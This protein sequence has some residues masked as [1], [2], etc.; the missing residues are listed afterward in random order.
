LEEQTVPVHPGA[1]IIGGGIAGLTSAE[2]LA[3]QGFKCTLVEKNSSLGGHLAEMK[4]TLAGE[5][6][7][8]VI[9]EIIDRVKKNRNIEV[10]TSSKL[11]EVSGFIGNFSSVIKTAAGKKE[12]ERTIEHGVIILATG[13]R[14]YRPDLYMLGKTKKVITQKELEI[15]LAGKAR[16]RA[17]D[18]VVMIQCAGS[19]GEDLTYCSKVCCGNAVKN[20]LK[21]KEINPDSQVMVLYRDMRTYGYAEDAYKK[22]REKGVVF[23]PYEPGQR[24]VVAKKGNSIDVTWLDP[25]LG[26]DV[27]FNPEIIVLSVGI[28]PEETRELGKKLKLSI[29]ENQFYM[30]AHVK[31]RPVEMSVDGVYVC[32]LAHSPKPVDEIIAQAQAAAG[33]AAIPLYKGKVAVPPVV[34]VID[35][36]KCIGCSICAKLCPYNA[37]QMIKEG[38]KPK[39]ETIVASCKGCGICASRCPSFAISMGGFT[40][41]QIQAQIKA[42]S[43]EF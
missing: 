5:S 29:N 23:I 16:K 41:E 37:I 32:G 17:P 25:I 13:G 19:R 11:Q 30:E 33:K 6:T 22:A 8:P 42:L 36:E 7:G 35:K 18:S 38:K 26:E 21:I 39:A 20:A 43:P 28:V 10:L 34:A 9:R 12:T 2:S 24:P 1:L 4:W 40:G 27:T 15:R 31:L 3:D 14:E